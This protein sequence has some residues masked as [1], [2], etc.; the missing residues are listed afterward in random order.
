MSN[1]ENKLN[2]L[3]LFSGLGGFTYGMDKTGGFETVAFC[4]IDEMCSDHL[5]KKWPGKPVFANIEHLSYCDGVL[6]YEVPHSETYDQLKTDIDVIVGGYPCTGHS[7]AGKKDGFK[8][9]GSKLWIEYLRLVSE[10]KPKYCI[11]ENSPN[12]R[13]TGL[14]EMLQAF[15]EIGYNAEWSVISA[16][17]V[18]SPH[19]RE[20]LYIVLWR[21]DV[22]YCNPFRFWEADLAQEKATSWWWPK[23]RIKRSA[24]FK[25]I[26]SFKQRILSTASGLSEQ[27]LRLND[28]HVKLIG[29]SLVPQIPELIGMAIWEN[30]L[31]GS[32][33]CQN[34]QIPMESV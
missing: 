1:L 5:K 10:I 6:H 17:S 2:V 8:D 31:Q 20:R 23:R 21:D 4:E 16:Y 24:V 19:Q 14:V 15:H 3:D 18:G 29:N 11:I 33:E 25:K 12:L 7:V 30:E 13:N 9:E 22:P 26:R 28:D 34:T 27:L 32:N